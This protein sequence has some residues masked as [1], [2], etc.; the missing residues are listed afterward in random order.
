MYYLGI[1]NN[2]AS[3]LWFTLSLAGSRKKEFIVS[4]RGAGGGVTWHLKADRV[5]TFSSDVSFVCLLTLWYR[6]LQR[7]CV[8]VLAAGGDNTVS[9]SV[10]CWTCV[11]SEGS[12]CVGVCVC[13]WGRHASC[14][15]GSQ[16][17]LSLPR[18]ALLPLVWM[19]VISWC[20]CCCQSLN[21]AE[22][23]K[24]WVLLWRQGEDSSTFCYRQSRRLTDDCVC[25]CFYGSQTL[26]HLH[27][28]PCTHPNPP[29][30]T[31]LICVGL[32]TDFQIWT[33]EVWTNVS[34]CESEQN[35]MSLA[36][37]LLVDWIWVPLLLRG[38][39]WWDCY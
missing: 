25:V 22:N 21:E 30:C 9:L 26:A 28:L 24:V 38:I 35:Q 27:L 39:K 4:G 29:L 3:A 6:G 10:S 31:F 13:V 20:C 1:I 33:D 2:N 23:C 14:V 17:F 5:C 7:D 15:G 37:L 16:F 8:C 19:C 11:F 18:L 12:G 34:D 36:G 32:E